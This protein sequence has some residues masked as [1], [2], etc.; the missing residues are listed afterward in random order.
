MFAKSILAISVVTGSI[1]AWVV[2]SKSDHT[3]SLKKSLELKRRENAELSALHA[4]LRDK[5]K[6]DAAPI[7]LED[8]HSQVLLGLRELALAHDIRIS[9]LAPERQVSTT[10][11]S[12]E[13][14]ADTVPG[15][16]SLKSVRY[17]LVATYKY[18]DGLRSFL[19]GTQRFP[20]SV[21]HFNAEQNTFTLIFRTYGLASAK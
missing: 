14:L 6:P 2:T 13:S 18:Y 12:L 4:Q 11:S 7:L 17:R 1:S 19:E 10:G 15:S 5:L 3:V 16:K 8:A 20:M 9:A 21:V